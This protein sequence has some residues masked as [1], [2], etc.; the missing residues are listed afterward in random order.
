MHNASP[1]LET[2]VA[3]PKCDG[4]DNFKKERYQVV[5][6]E[7]DGCQGVKEVVRGFD[8]VVTNKWVFRWHRSFTVQ[9]SLV[10]TIYYCPI[11]TFV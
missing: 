5:R 11:E 8:K 1:V 10:H 2:F 9:V 6:F 7:F 3:C 4:R